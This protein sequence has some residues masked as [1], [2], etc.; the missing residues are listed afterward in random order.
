M[1]SKERTWKII[2]KKLLPFKNIFSKQ[3]TNALEIIEEI[4][5]REINNERKYKEFE[6][7][8]EREMK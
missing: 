4:M 3:E 1:M 7:K 5:A 8:L 2:R 6:K